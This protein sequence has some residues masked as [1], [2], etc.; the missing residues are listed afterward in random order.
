MTSMQFDPR[1]RLWWAL[2][3]VVAAALFVV[4]LSDSVYNLTSPPGPFQI[5][6]RKGY[7]IVAF[8]VVGWL[9]AR[10]LIASDTPKSALFVGLFIA[11]YSALIEISQAIGQAHEGF[12]WNVV[13]VACGFLGGVLGA[14][15]LRMR[16]TSRMR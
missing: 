13:D 6:L 1:A 12:I 10:S 15:L 16:W 7:S 4:A 11:N 14:W 5:L 3:I 2:T 8:A 9:F